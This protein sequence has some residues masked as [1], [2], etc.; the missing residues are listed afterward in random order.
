VKRVGFE[1]NMTFDARLVNWGNREG[2]A[3]VQTGSDCVHARAEPVVDGG[4]ARRGQRPSDSMRAVGVVGGAL[5]VLHV[6]GAKAVLSV[7]PALI[8]RCIKN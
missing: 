5:A 4:R 7:K 2:R 1:L 8:E 3:V 6:T